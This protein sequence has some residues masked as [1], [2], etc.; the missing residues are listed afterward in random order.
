MNPWSPPRKVALIAFLTS[1]LLLGGKFIAY[2]L[3]GSAAALSDALESIINVVTGAF[4]LVSVAISS[5]PADESH[6]YGHGKIEAFSAGLEG[7]LILLAAMVILGEAAPRFLVPVPP[8]RL[9]L[10]TI[11]L[12]GAGIINL[13][14]GL[15][16]CYYG[17]RHRSEA[18]EADGRHLLTDFYTSA[19]VVLGLL[20]VRS[21]GW[22]WLDPLVACLVA[23]QILVP[24][25]KL[26]RNAVRN[27]MNE[28]DPQILQRVV[29]ALAN[30][31][32][33]VWLC[34][35]DLR[36]IRSGNYHHIDL[37]IT[38]PHYWRL[39]QAHAVEK[40]I[41]AKL[42]AT[43]GTAGDV[44][45]HLDPCDSACCRSCRLESCPER[46]APFAGSEPLRMENIIGPDPR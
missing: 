25:T 7:G 35:H 6:P 34:P 23:I 20:G 13:I 17:R 46:Q 40:E 39:G 24:G 42:L 9:G 21:T 45:I 31:E 22:L 33:P 10:G 32:S 1:I 18:L 27:L 28:A 29:D 26:V 3:T 11:L 38:L 30:M 12:F 41:A 43:V 16:V 36:V 15:S 2:Y 8:Q 44:M 5:R 19:G 37:H 4:M 14:L